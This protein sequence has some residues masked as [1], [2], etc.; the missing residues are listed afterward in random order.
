[1]DL[2]TEIRFLI[3]EELILIEGPPEIHVHPMYL[4]GYSPVFQRRVYP[5]KP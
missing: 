3:M 4:I 5:S 1:M 2:P